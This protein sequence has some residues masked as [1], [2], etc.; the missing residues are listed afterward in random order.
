MVPAAVAREPV[1]RVSEERVAAGVAR[2]A[3]S[4]EAEEA[5]EACSLVP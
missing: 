2:V 1:A 4:W 3:E 5:F